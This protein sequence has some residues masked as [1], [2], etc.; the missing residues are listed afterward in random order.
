MKL[1]TNINQISQTAFLTLQCHAIDAKSDSPILNDK[2]AIKVLDLLKELVK[3]SNNSLYKRLINDKV[4][5]NLITHT[6]LR[7][8]EY[9]SFIRRFIEK[10]PAATVVNIGCGLD[11]RFERID[12]ANIEFYDLD[13][14]DIIEI[15]EQIFPPK[16]RYHQIAQ[17]VFEK[18]WIDQI[19]AKNVI[20][21]AE[22]V[23]MYCEECNIKSLF[24]QLQEKLNNPEIVFEVFN[25]KWMK[26][27]RRKS[28][29]F[30]MKKQLKLGEDTIFKFGIT[31]S[32][33][34]EAWNP[35]Y[36]L[37]KDWSY[38]DSL[39]G[40]VLI[41]LFGKSNALRKIQWTV[42]YALYD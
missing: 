26:G 4:K 10:H 42:H 39:Q 7:A 16:H 18:D 13:F 22:G 1:K 23:F 38:F 19:S 30:K 34:I 27:W 28:M 8:K 11:N 5:R 29:E 33:E 21:V 15:K 12:N 6:A 14:P 41:K 31:D 35:G 2:S 24:H 9:D 32:D 25:K 17:S 3:D 36:K 20:L 37:I 40:S